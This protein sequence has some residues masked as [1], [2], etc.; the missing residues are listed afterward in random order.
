M[1]YSS[2]TAYLRIEPPAWTASLL[3]WVS[4]LAIGICALLLGYSGTNVILGPHFDWSGVVLGPVTVAEM[5]ATRGAQ[6]GLVTAAF[7]PGR[8]QPVT[9]LVVTS[10]GLDLGTV[11][12]GEALDRD[13]AAIDAMP[14]L[15]T[16]ALTLQLK[17]R[18][19]SQIAPAGLEVTMSRDSVSRADS[20]GRWLI[21][22]AVPDGVPS[23]EYKAYV[24]GAPDRR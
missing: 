13:L 3:A 9:R 11:F 12:V 20:S 2:N 7:G 4:M 8:P 10:D 5:A 24:P 23:G 15:V 14:A 17:S 19:G 21:T 18:V 16:S 6:T 22:V 1:V